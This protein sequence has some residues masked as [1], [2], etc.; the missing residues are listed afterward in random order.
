MDMTWERLILPILAFI[1][2]EGDKGLYTGTKKGMLQIRDYWRF[3]NSVQRPELAIY[4]K[5]SLTHWRP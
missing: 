1:L 2:V 4:E 3:Y 5:W